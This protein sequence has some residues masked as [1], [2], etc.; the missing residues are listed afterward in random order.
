MSH[1]LGSLTRLDGY[2]PYSEYWVSSCRTEVPTPRHTELSVGLKRGPFAKP[3]LSPA[4]S[5]GAF[6]IDLHLRPS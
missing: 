5:R 6:W 4:P 3:P 1:L 2:E